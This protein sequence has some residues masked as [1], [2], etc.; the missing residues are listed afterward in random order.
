MFHLIWYIIV[1]LVA[2]Y[3]AKSVM[4]M[5]LSLTWT[6]VLGVIGSI[7]GAPSRICFIRQVPEADFTPAV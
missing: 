3:V 5:H 6:I 7:I 1:G 4:H 2:G